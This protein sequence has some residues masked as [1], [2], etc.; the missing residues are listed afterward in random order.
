MR[1]IRK[2]LTPFVIVASIGLVTVTTDSGAADLPPADAH[3]FKPDPDVIDPVTGKYDLVTNRRPTNISHLAVG[4]DVSLVEDTLNATVGYDQGFLTQ[5]EEAST[6]T[7]RRIVQVPPGQASGETVATATGF[8]SSFESPDLVVLRG[9]SRRWGGVFDPNSSD[10]T[11]SLT[12]YGPQSGAFSTPKSF[13][14][15]GNGVQGR[16]VGVVVVS[17]TTDDNTSANS[18]VLATT[19]GVYAFGTPRCVSGPGGTVCDEFVLQ[20]SRVYSPGRT[21]L[22]VHHNPVSRLSAIE[23]FEEEYDGVNTADGA[24][25]KNVLDMFGVLTSDTS[26]LQP[27]KRR[28]TV[29]FLRVKDALLPAHQIAPAVPWSPTQV[30]SATNPDFISGVPRGGDLRYGIGNNGFGSGDNGWGHDVRVDINVTLPDRSTRQY[31]GN[32]VN[33]EPV[34]PITTVAAAGVPLGCTSPVT[35]FDAA[36][37]DAY[38]GN[39][40]LEAHVQCATPGYLDN[41]FG[42]GLGYVTVSGYHT[43]GATGAAGAATLVPDLP[44]IV[45]ADGAKAVRPQVSVSLPCVEMVRYAVR[46]QHRSGTANFSWPALKAQL[47]SDRD[48]IKSVNN[49]PS[50]HACSAGAVPQGVFPYPRAGNVEVAVAVNRADRSADELG[51]LH[52]ATATTLATIGL[53]SDSDLGFYRGDATIQPLPVRSHIASLPSTDTVE[54]VRLTGSS[55]TC[56]TTASDAEKLQCRPTTSFGA[57]VPI[58]VMATPPYLEG[59][60]QQGEITSEFATSTTSSQE[61]T[62]ATSTS[63][64]VEVELGFK[65]EFEDPVTKVKASSKV[66]AALGYDRTGEHET[67]KSFT[68]TKSNGYGGSFV[69]DTMVVNL[70]RYLSY[71]GVVV[72]STNGLGLCDRADTAAPCEPASTRLSVPVAN[73]VTSMTVDDLRKDPATA[74]WWNPTGAFGRG[75]AATLT[76]VSGNPATYLGNSS[77]DP[78]E[79]VDDYCLGD[80]DPTQGFVEVAQGDPTPA[81][82]FTGTKKLSETAAQILTSDWRAATAGDDV[83]SQRANLEYSSARG[84]SFLQTNTISASTSVEGEYGAGGLTGSAKLTLSAGGSIGEGYSASLGNGTAFSGTVGSIPDSRLQDE[85]FTWR[86]FVCKRELVPGVPVWV[87]NYQVFG[88]HGVYDDPVARDPEELGVVQATSPV[89]SAVASV[90]PTFRWSQPDGTVKSYDLELEA[91]GASDERVLPAAVS[92]PDFAAASA[93]PDATE[94]ALP[95]DQALLPGQLYRWRVTSNNFLYR[96]ET[97]DWQYFVTAGPQRLSVG[98]ASVVEGASSTRAARFT[99]SLSAPAAQDVHFKYGTVPASAMPIDSPIGAADFTSTSGSGV[100][101]AGLTSTVV[102][103]PIHGDR[104]V[105]GTE[106][107]LVAISAVSP[108]AVLKPA[109]YGFILDD[110]ASAGAG[111]SIGDASVVEGKRGNRSLRFTVSRNDRDADPL[112]VGYTT[113]PGTATPGSDFIAKS[114]TVTI[115]ADGTS[116][117]IRIPVQPDAAKESHETLSVWLTAP[118]GG[119]WYRFGGIGTIL[120][121]D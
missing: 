97:S 34:I 115:P 108:V 10:P 36:Y 53:F 4:D 12:W 20:G 32:R 43:S 57:P 35:G 30:D 7:V 47:K 81:N 117:V 58:A 65:A 105:E 23:Q 68:V 100:V 15:A 109:A 70:A 37:F 51:S 14:L 106:L 25:G 63:V 93:R 90:T 24:A 92:Y 113:G 52:Q 55:A 16:P 87:Q 39:R 5:P 69:N 61:E 112:T 54:R 56:L 46:S 13:D 11:M 96:S 3:F 31:T 29:E 101:E 26:A 64:G 72:S 114:G 83:N 28:L 42:T 27:G 120:D 76:H 8:F 38:N 44:Q 82:P 49:W 33:P 66:S 98:D 78:D 67:S 104:D 110:E 45:W 91:I 48:F 107:F 2:W 121:D 19:H 60:G 84:E 111:I 9:D 21:V 22:A 88:Y 95:S 59:S 118:N 40:R 102:T 1:G 18:V 71:Q 77:A 79:V 86:M 80:L 17:G 62:K 89:K 119:Q 41:A 116:A 75:L 99:V 94:Y 103:V 85:Q 50:L 74:A 6:Q 73:V